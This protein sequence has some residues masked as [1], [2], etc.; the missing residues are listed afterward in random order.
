MSS[1]DGSPPRE[2]DLAIVGGGILGTAV[3]RELLA[4][5]PGARLCVLE[6]EDGLGRH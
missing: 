5:R 3:A 1:A 6:A 4:R 2:C